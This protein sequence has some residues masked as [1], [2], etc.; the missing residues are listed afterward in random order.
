[1]GMLL[2]SV[3]ELIVSSLTGVLWWLIP[4]EIERR[5][6]R[7]RFLEGRVRCAIRA[8]RGR[9][10]NVGTEWSGGVATISKGRL[11]FVPSIGIVG[12]R[13]IQVLGIRDHEDP[14]PA[15]DDEFILGEWLDFVVTTSAGELLVRFPM[16]VGDAAA[17][18]LRIAIERST[19]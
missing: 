18:V 2:Q 1:M 6:D 9:V 15:A 12:D 14:V 19:P 17:D 8:T 16:E 13:D 4:D 10:L 5:R 3:V 7:S 11:Y